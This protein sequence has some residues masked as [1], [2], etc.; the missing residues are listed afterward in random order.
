MFG[1][2]AFVGVGVVYAVDYV[3]REGAVLFIL[4]M[5]DIDICGWGGEGW[6]YIC[7]GSRTVAITLPTRGWGSAW[8]MNSVTTSSAAARTEDALVRARARVRML[9]C[10]VYRGLVVGVIVGGV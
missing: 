6:G 7:I 9:L 3:G 4:S 2:A 10:M 5:L 8:G 1:H